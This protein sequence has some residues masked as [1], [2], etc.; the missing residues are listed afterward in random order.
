M[1]QAGITPEIRPVVAGQP[2]GG[3]RPAS[4]PWP[5]N[6]PTARMVTGKT[7]ELMGC[8]RRRPAQRPEVRWPG[9]GAMAC[10]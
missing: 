7:S 5:S 8:V 3:R 9:W 6:C 10:I 4:L 2:A 1:Q